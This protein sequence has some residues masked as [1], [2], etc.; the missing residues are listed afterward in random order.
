MLP[1]ILHDLAV[2]KVFWFQLT[3]Y[4]PDPAFDSHGIFD[5]QGQPKL[6]A[7]MYRDLVPGI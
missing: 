2:E 5:T 1:F 7:C 6:G 3:D 4:N